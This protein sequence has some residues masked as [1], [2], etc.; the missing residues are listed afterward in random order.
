V[1]V[2]SAQETSGARPLAVP[3]VPYLP[4]TAALCGGAALAMVLRYWGAPGV[5]PEDF[6]AALLPSDRGIATGTLARLAEERGYE[7]LV[8]RGDPAEAAA[9]LAK[10]RPLIALAGGAGGSSGH[11]VVLLAW[12]NERVLLHDPAVGPFRVMTEEEWLDEWNAA[13]G[14]TLLVVPGERRDEPSP[15]QTSLEDDPCA[16]LV[17][18]AI[19]KADRGDLASARR[20]LAAAAELCPGSSAP[21][22]EMAG[23]EF[24]R[25]SWA[26]A[27]DLAERALARRPDDS[28]SWRLL[29]TSRFLEGEPDDAL[30]AWNRV[31]EP[32][33]DLVSVEGLV[34][35]PFRAV[36]DS[37]GLGP[38][39][40]LT[41][42]LLRRAGRRVATLP[43]SH[44]SRVS[45]RPLPGGRAQLDVAIVERPTIDPLRPLLVESALRA[46]TDRRVGLSLANLT[47]TGDR[48]RVL[49]QWQANRPQVALAASAP[50]ALGLPGIVTAEAL[51]DE[52]SYRV[53]LAG[54]GAAVV[55]E[56]RRRASLSVED[57]WRA[58]TRAALS[59]AADQWNGRGGFV[60]IAGRLEHRLAGDRVSIGGELAGWAGPSGPPFHARALRLSARSTPASRRLVLRLD[61]AYEGASL[62]APLALWP[63]AGTGL[64]RD[65]LLRAHPLLTDGIVDGRC[66]GLE[67]LRGGLEGEAA[68]ASLGPV[69]LTAAVFVDSARVLV[70]APGTSSRPGFVDLGAGVRV[71]LPGSGQGLRLDVA[72]PWGRLRPQLSV[73]WQVAWP[74]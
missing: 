72:T 62:R 49:W 9:Q 22:R 26:S 35:T 60:S 5:R 47:G 69:G 70:P 58:D 44:G 28:L 24:R 3:A 18:P 54:A 55:R 66:F 11:Y 56:T 63:G 39:D 59:V 41:P 17:R 21:L 71:H 2:A 32:R 48:G 40:V 10:G 23:L 57:W 14:W 1:A 13:S 20:E 27:A 36:Y 37:L 50:R 65:L 46:F 42:A 15:D 51:W 19:E 61:L 34:R 67:I 12:A 7:A 43:A 38:D 73:G 16:A 52:Q 31:S 6:A 68:L 4:Q 53:P 8:F 25:E 33:L 74:D 29:A 64:G 45:Y 30:E